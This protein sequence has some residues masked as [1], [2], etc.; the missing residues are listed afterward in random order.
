MLL[1]RLRFDFL[2][3]LIL[4][5]FDM[6]SFALFLL[7][8]FGLTFSS[9]FQSIPL[10]Q[11]SSSS[12]T[13]NNSMLS[14]SSLSNEG[15][16]R[17]FWLVDFSFPAFGGRATLRGVLKGMGLGS[18]ASLSST[19][20]GCRF[21][22]PGVRPLGPRLVFAKKLQLR[23]CNT[24]EFAKRFVDILCVLTFCDRF[25]CKKKERISRRC[26]TYSKL[27]ASWAI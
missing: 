26:I 7:V 4:P 10:W 25:D 3:E 23:L 15:I 1:T 21:L 19:V 6:T 8:T 2:C 16:F 12:P 27:T 18:S 11:S 13:S 5:F 24:S 20:F 17:R 9:S 14:S 22:V